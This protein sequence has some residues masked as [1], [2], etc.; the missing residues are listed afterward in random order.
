MSRR[1]IL[2]VLFVGGMVLVAGCS[3]TPATDSTQSPTT[4]APTTEETQTLTSSG[5]NGT[6]TVY[7]LNVGQG[8]SILVVG[9]TGETLLVDSG[10][11]RAEGETVLNTLDQLGIERIDYLVTSHPDADHIGGHAEI[12]NHLETEGEGVGVVYDPGIT[13][14]SQTYQDYLDA[15]EAHD[16][17]LYK[18][19]AGDTIPLEDATVQILGPPEGY[20]DNEDRNENSLVLHIAH[21]GTSVL[22]PGDAESDSESYL[23]DEYGEQLN[24]TVL[25]PGH[26][27]SASSSTES[28]LESVDPRIA[29]ITSAYDSQYG[30]PNEQTLQRLAAQEVRTYWTGTHGTTKLTSNGTHLRVATEYDGP[31]EPLQLRDGEGTTAGPYSTLTDRFVLDVSSGGESKIIADGGETESTTTE[32]GSGSTGELAVATIHADAEGDDRE[33]LNDEYVVFSNTGDSSLDLSGW[34]VT[35]EVGTT[36]TVPEGVT[37]DPGTDLTLRTGSGDDTESELYWG[38]ESAIWNNGGDTV[39]VRDDNGSIITEESYN[40]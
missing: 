36:Y 35:D 13:S 12:I 17:T 32:S 14:T 9:P 20:V 26:H 16:V 22:I 21:G 4:E 40:G 10:D 8:A 37:L 2:L 7:V 29:T 18:S 23:V 11:W 24:S 27:G 3:G 30:H 38:S 6:L 39:I 31:T 19:F 5:G 28:F 1:Q 33:N 34:T 15:I 25:V